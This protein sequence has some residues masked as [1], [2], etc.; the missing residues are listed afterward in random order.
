M[1]KKLLS[2]TKRRSPLDIARRSA[3]LLKRYGMTSK[4]LENNLQEYISLAEDFNAGVTFPITATTLKNNMD[5]IFS[6]KAKHVEWA[7]HGYI[8]VEY[9]NLAPQVIDTHIKKAISI[10][11]E[12]KINPLGFRAP[13]LKFDSKK[14]RILKK[15]GLI[16]DSSRSYLIENY[17]GLK[18]IVEYYNPMEKWKITKT[19]GVYEIPVTLPDD[20]I[21]IDRLGMRDK[22]LSKHLLEVVKKSLKAGVIPVLQLHPERWQI[23]KGALEKVM[24]WATE[25]EIKMVTLYELTK[26]KANKVMCIT[27]DIDIMKIS[28]FAA[29]REQKW[30]A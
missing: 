19:N 7:I 18:K 28:D 27:G 16:Y 29:T 22:Q 14:L 11:H 26:T 6:L 9:D 5:S 25:N 20:E 30:Q 13:Y 10:F 17:P 4:K 1:I 15:N 8:H 21:F 3:T 23:F 24:L 12:A 2:A